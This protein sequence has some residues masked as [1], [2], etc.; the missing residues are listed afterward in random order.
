MILVVAS[1]ATLM[2]SAAYTPGRLVERSIWEGK[3]WREQQSAW[4]RRYGDSAHV[5]PAGDRDGVQKRHGGEG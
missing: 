5:P 2:L 4:E 3:A 1:G